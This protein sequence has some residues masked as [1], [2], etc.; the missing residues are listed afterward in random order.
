MHKIVMLTPIF[1]HA[2]NMEFILEMYGQ[3]YYPEQYLTELEDT[4]VRQSQLFFGLP[5]DK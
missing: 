4:L 5:V 1:F 2:T 3:D